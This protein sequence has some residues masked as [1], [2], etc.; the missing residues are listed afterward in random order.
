[1][2]RLVRPVSPENAPS[3]IV[4]TLEGIVIPVRWVQPIKAFPLMTVTVEGIVKEVRPA[5][6]KACRPMVVTLGGMVKVV[7]AVSPANML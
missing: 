4:G 2:V 5:L 1:M 7:K 6:K 3:P